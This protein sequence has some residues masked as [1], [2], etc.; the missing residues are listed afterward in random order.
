MDY[1]LLL[2]S[3]FQG[4]NE[5][6]EFLSFKL[7]GTSDAGFGLLGKWVAV[8]TAIF[9]VIIINVFLA[10]QQPPTAVT[11]SY[12]PHRCLPLPTIT[13]VATRCLRLQSVP[14]ATTIAHNCPQLQRPQAATAPVQF[15]NRLTRMHVALFHKTFM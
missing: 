12:A 7:F 11:V 4:L 3:I 14:L 9:R 1:V 2:L 5:T 15:R 10:H 13:T 8:R 6:F